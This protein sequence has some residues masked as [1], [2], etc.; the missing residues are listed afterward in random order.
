[1]P[2]AQSFEQPNFVPN[3]TMFMPTGSFA[4]IPV[5]VQTPDA[6]VGSNV[7]GTPGARGV[8]IPFLQRVEAQSPLLRQPSPSGSL[9]HDPSKQMP[10]AQ[11][12]SISQA[13]PTGRTVQIPRDLRRISGGICP[14]VLDELCPDVPGVLCSTVSGELC[15]VVSGVISPSLSGLACPV[16]SD[17]RIPK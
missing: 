3:L 15:P 13:D 4:Q 7:Q 10:D 6:Q 17:P 1:M 9:V 16:L 8:Q 12:L 14:A 5:S 11:L 2:D